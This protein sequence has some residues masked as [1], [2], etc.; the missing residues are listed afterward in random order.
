MNEKQVGEGVKA[1]I[2][3]G[4]VKRDELFLATKIWHNAYAD[5]ETA[6]RKSLKTMQIDYV[7]LYYVH[8][9]NNFVSGAD[10]PMHVLWKRME[11]LVDRGLCKGIGLSNFNT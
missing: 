5:P 2:E 3:D 6:L 4:S 9:P 1:A 7:D 8:W 10:V 11:G